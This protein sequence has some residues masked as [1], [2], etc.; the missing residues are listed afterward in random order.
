MIFQDPSSCLNPVHTIGFYLT[1]ALYRHQGLTGQDARLEAVRLL[2]RVGID[3]AGRRLQAYPH[4]FSGGM[5]QR[6][7]IAHALAA[8]PRLLIADE[9]TTALDVT[10]QAQILSLLE[11]L[12]AETEM[13]ILIVSHDLGVIAQMADRTAVM[14]GGRILETAA[15][16]QLLENASHPY[17]RALIACMPSVDPDHKDP[18]KPIPDSVLQF[19]QAGSSIQGEVPAGR[20]QAENTGLHAEKIKRDDNIV[21]PTKPGTPILTA[22]QLTKTFKSRSGWFSKPNMN[23]AVESVSLKLGHRERLGLVGESGSGKSTLGRLLLG[24]IE[25]TEGEVIFDGVSHRERRAADWQA[26]RKQTALVQQNP[27]SALNPQMTVGEQV[28]EPVW[29]HRVGTR[30][31]ARNRA[32]AMLDRVGLTTDLMNRFPHQLSGGQRQRVVTARAL[33]LEPKLVIFDEAVSALDVSVQAQ[34]VGQLKSLWTE[35]DL[36]YV[37]ITHDLRIVRHLVDRI[38]VMRQGEIVEVGD[39]DSVYRRPQH[40]YTQ[41][42]LSAVPSIVPRAKSL[43]PCRTDSEKPSLLKEGETI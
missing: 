10:T 29:V 35:L 32:A 2:E 8:K 25:P 24:L 40:P 1:S 3:Q 22:S 14:Y 16:P 33:I 39:I 13:A 20:S 18:P 36:T 9:P 42:L 34:I 26:F 43:A 11:E 27:L 19:A 30:S 7:M 31:Q 41:A 4:Q 6:V 37:F 12:R 28:A 15:T 38:A 5:N 17:T 21:V 23:T